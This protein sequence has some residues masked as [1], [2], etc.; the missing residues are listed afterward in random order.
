MCRSGAGGTGCWKAGGCS[1]WWCH[2]EG[3]RATASG[4]TLEG[5]RHGRRET[6]GAR[7]AQR[8]KGLTVSRF[9]FVG[10]IVG[11]GI[12]CHGPREKS[13]QRVTGYRERERAC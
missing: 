8:L 13:R 1:G 7:D 6:D 11:Y 10:E 4:T 2:V 12:L 3:S 5:R 9:G